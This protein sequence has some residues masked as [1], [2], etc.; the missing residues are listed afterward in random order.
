MIILLQKEGARKI[1]QIQQ[2][3]GSS[4]IT[5]S[6]GS[7][8]IIVCN[9]PDALKVLNSAMFGDRFTKVYTACESLSSDDKSDSAIW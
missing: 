8:K 1:E 5:L 6:F 2:S 3:I 9:S 4:V 7:R